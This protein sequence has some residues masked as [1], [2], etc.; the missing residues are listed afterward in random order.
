MVV[1]SEADPQQWVNDLRIAA[2]C[3]TISGDAV[4]ARGYAL[5]ALIYQEMFNIVGES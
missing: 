3:C 2:A 1:H 4:S 5:R